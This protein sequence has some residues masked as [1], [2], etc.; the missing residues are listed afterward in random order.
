MSRPIRFLNSLTAL[1]ATVEIH[2]APVDQLNQRAMDLDRDVEAA[3]FAA[4]L[5]QAIQ[6]RKVMALFVGFGC[7]QHS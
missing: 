3:H 7:S 2:L 6:K 4:R 5:L 1:E